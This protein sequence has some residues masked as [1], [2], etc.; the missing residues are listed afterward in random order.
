MLFPAVFFFFLYFLSGTNRSTNNSTKFDSILLCFESRLTKF[1][2][3]T[4]C[5]TGIGAQFPAC[6][7]NN[8]LI[9]ADVTEMKCATTITTTNL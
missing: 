1:F 6:M 8:C 3:L 5:S 2:L 7:S 9:R 4:H